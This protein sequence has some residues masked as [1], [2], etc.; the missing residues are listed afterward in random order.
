LGKKPIPGIRKGRKAAFHLKPWQNTPFSDI[1]RRD[2]IAMLERIRATAPIQS[3]RV[4]AVLHGL[5]GYAVE[6]ELA[7]ANPVAAIK[8]KYKEKPRERSLSEDEIKTLWSAL[9]AAPMGEAVQRIL[10]LVLLSGQ[11]KGEVCAMEWSDIDLSNKLWT[12]PETKFKGKRPHEVPI[13]DAAMA[14]LDQQREIKI[15]R[16]VFPSV[17]D[18]RPI[19]GTS[20]DHAVRRWLENGLK[21]EHWTPHDLRR[22]VR[23]QMAVMGISEEI[24]ERVIGHALAGLTKVYNRHAYR[25]EKRRALEAWAARLEEIT[26][27]VKHDQQK[28]IQIHAAA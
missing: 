23:T 24:A 7:E 5:W 20:V 14:I 28:V 13:S 8:R 26:T 6:A 18:D 4:R 3:N 9:P 2:I 19:A 15:N 11:R 12:I 17:S 27:G 10:K 25:D 16:W 21:I 1:R 22:T